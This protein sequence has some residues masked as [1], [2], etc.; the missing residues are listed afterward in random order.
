MAIAAFI[1]RLLFGRFFLYFLYQGIHHFTHYL[2]LKGYAAYKGIPAPGAAVL[3]SGLM[4]LYGG[5][6]WIL[7]T[8]RVS[9]AIVLAIALLGFSLGVRHCWAVSDPQARQGDQVDFLRNLA[10]LGAL[11]AL[12]VAPPTVGALGA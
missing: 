12:L 7:G 2:A 6:M 11:L 9:A 10:L 8:A 4:L 5:V 3:C 1:G